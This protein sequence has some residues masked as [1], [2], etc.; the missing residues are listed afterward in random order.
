MNTCDIHLEHVWYTSWTC[1]VYI[2]NMC[3]IYLEYVWYISWTCIYLEHVWYTFWTCVVYILNMWYLFLQE[4]YKVACCR[5]PVTNIASK[6]TFVIS[7]SFIGQGVSKIELIIALTIRYNYVDIW[8]PISCRTSM[9]S[10]CTS[11]CL[12]CTVKCA[13]NN[14][15]KTNLGWLWSD[16]YSPMGRK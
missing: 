10:I 11:P 9:E 8:F 4:F 6:E 14:T 16:I 15:L 12:L 5:N 1:V 3:G 13:Y 7:S 2:L